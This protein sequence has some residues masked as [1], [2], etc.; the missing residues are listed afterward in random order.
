MAAALANL[1]TRPQMTSQGGPV[2]PAGPEQPPSLSQVSADAMART[3]QPAS[4]AARFAGAEAPAFGM[5]TAPAQFGALSAFTPG[6]RGASIVPSQAAP[7]NQDDINTAILEYLRRQQ[8]PTQIYS[9]F[10]DY[11]SGPYDYATAPG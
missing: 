1:A 10:G 3:P 7:A 8:Q 6:N 5:P 2:P 4:F 11:G 9:G